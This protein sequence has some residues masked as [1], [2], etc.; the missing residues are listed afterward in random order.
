MKTHRLCFLRTRSSVAFPVS[1]TLRDM[2][3]DTLSCGL[4]PGLGVGFPACF[5]SVSFRFFVGLLLGCLA[6]LWRRAFAFGRRAFSPSLFQP[7]SRFLR[8]PRLSRHLAREASLLWN[9]KQNTRRL[10]GRVHSHRGLFV[11]PVVS[12]VWRRF[13]QSQASFPG[14]NLPAASPEVGV[15]GSHN[16]PEARLV[17]GEPHLVKR[18]QHEAFRGLR[19]QSGCG[20]G[21]RFSSPSTRPP[22]YGWRPV[23]QRFAGNPSFPFRGFP[24]T[25]TGLFS[26]LDI[27]G[28][29][30]SQ[31]A[32]VR[33]MRPCESTAGLSPVGR[34]LGG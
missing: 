21:S 10:H 16:L 9:G 26:D 20:W 8:L 19:N 7:L 14:T 11:A 25:P 34:A 32:S 1:K 30:V 15:S 4:G 3:R 5:W 22:L 2:S 24:G 23:W 12:V 13:S 27:G 17:R 29:Q 18:S 6:R 33:Q 31:R 28:G